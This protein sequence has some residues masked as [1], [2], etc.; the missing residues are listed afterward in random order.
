ML[1]CWNLLIEVFFFFLKLSIVLNFK[2]CY[3]LG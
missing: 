2:E 3:L 1:L